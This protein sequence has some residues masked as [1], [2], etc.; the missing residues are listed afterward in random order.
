MV[1][2]ADRLTRQYDL[3]PLD[4]LGLKVNIIGAGAVGSFTALTLAKM[5]FCNIE[6]WD[7]DTIEVENMNCQFYRTADIG[8]EKG[9]ALKEL[10]KDFTDVDIV[11]HNEWYE[12]KELEGLV[13]MAVDSMAVRK[14]IYTCNVGRISVPYIIDSRMGG[15]Y[16]QLY[17]I[18]N[19]DSK[20]T[21]NYAKSLYSDEDAEHERCTAKATM[22]TVNLIAGLIGK[23]VKDI[24]NSDKYTKLVMWDVKNNC[25]EGYTN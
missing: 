5:G 22:Y 19:T 8:R 1:A 24:V 6:V 4:K 21:S 23:V 20:A 15:E 25:Y 9:A 17:C 11:Y 16:I 12:G 7:K 13:I 3:L 14:I 2:F 10:V 18:D